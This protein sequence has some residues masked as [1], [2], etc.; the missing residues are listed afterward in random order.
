MNNPVRSLFAI[1]AFAFGAL[2]AQAQ[3][4][5]VVVDMA[6]LFDSHYKTQEQTAKLQADEQKAQQ[7]L[8]KMNGEGNTLVEQLK[9]LQEQGNNPTATAEAKQKAAEAAQAKYGEIRKKQE[10]VNQYRENITRNLQTRFNNFKGIMLDEISKLAVDIATKK[11][12]ATLLLDKSGPSMIGI[13]AVVYSAPS[14]DITEEVLAEINKTRPATPAATATPAPA[15]AAP[16]APAAT[17]VSP[18]ITVPGAKK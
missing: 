13:P 18:S 6:K 15:S 16:A 14:L 4:N 10:E 3:T 12:S 5:I 7:E 17:S 9:E 2:L 8:E 11:H 1:G